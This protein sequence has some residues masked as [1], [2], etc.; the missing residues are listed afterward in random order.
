M[1]ETILFLLS[2]IRITSQKRHSP[3]EAARIITAMSDESDSENEMDIEHSETDSD[4]EKYYVEQ[5]TQL[6]C[7]SSSDVETFD[8]TIAT[9][10]TRDPLE[11][12]VT[13]EFGD[14][15]AIKYVGKN[16]RVLLSV[17]PLTSRIIYIKC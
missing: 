4:G 15:G 1:C 13:M 14:D 12:D 16:N 17:P 5:A 6:D 7:S 2:V 8:S 9:D 10:T 3:A 11:T